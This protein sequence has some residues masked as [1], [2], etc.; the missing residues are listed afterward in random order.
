ML[1]LGKKNWLKLSWLCLISYMPLIHAEF[2]DASAQAIA[3]RLAPIGSVKIDRPQPPAS[4]KNHISL[5]A[6]EHLGKQI[7]TTRCILCHGQGIGGAPRL[8]VKTDWEKRL[9]QNKSV[10]FDHLEQGYR[11]MPPKGACLECSN[12]DLHVALDYLLKQ[13]Q[14]L[15]S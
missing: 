7:V 13:I 5:A 14:T 9:K 8:T 3:K 12:N 10:L 4:T 1:R 2:F 15:T 11:A 6:A